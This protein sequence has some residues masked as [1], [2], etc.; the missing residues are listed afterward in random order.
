MT[1]SHGSPLLPLTTRRAPDSDRG[2]KVIHF[3]LVMPQVIANQIILWETG[4]R[5]PVDPREAATLLWS[6]PV[7]QFLNGQIDAWLNV[8]GLKLLVP[9]LNALMVRNPTT[10]PKNQAE[11]QEFVA[12][13]APGTLNSISLMQELKDRRTIEF[14]N[15]LVL[16]FKFAAIGYNRPLRNVAELYRLLYTLLK[17][18]N[19]P[20][21][22]GDLIAHLSAPLVTPRV[23]TTLPGPA[24]PRPPP[25]NP[26]P[27]KP[28]VGTIGTLPEHVIES[29]NNQLT[30]IESQN[31]ANRIRNVLKDVGLNDD[32]SIGKVMTALDITT[33]IPLLGEVADERTLDSFSTSGSKRLQSRLVSIRLFG[34]S[35][36]VDISELHA[37]INRQRRELAMRIQETLPATTRQR[38]QA[39]GVTIEDLT[40]W[41]H[42]IPAILPSPSYLEPI[43][44]SD[45]LLVRETTTGYRRSEIA[46]IENILIGESRNR[47]HTN[48]I[49]TRKEL[50]ESTTRETEETRDLQVTD[51][52]ELSREISKVVSED[53]KAQGNV[54]ITS[55]GPTKVVASASVSFERST[56]EAAKSAEDYSRE[57]IER[58]IKRTMERVTREARSVFEQEITEVNK[59]GFT[60]EGNAQE[61]MSGVY[62]YLER[63]S[64]ARIF[65]YGERELYD[66][67]IPEPASI[68]WQ[69]AATRKEIQ[70]AIEQPDEELFKSLTLA[71]I[72]SKREDIIRA[73]RVIDMPEVP[74]ESVEIATSFSATGSGDGAKYANSKEL[75]I[76][77]GYVVTS[78][79]FVASADVE[80]SSDKPNGG[81]TIAGE[82]Y[83]WEMQLSGN[84][85]SASQDFTF[86]PPLSG[87]M[88]SVAMNTDNFT[89]LVGSVTLKLE[90]TQAAREGWA[91]DAYGRVAERYEQLRREYEQTVIQANAVES[92]SSIILPEG[93]RSYLKNIVRAELQRAAIDVMRNQPV[94]YDLIDDF[95]FSNSDGTLGSHPVI[96]LN[97]LRRNGPE[98]QFLQQAFEWE[99]LAWILYPYFWGRRTEWDRTVVVSHTDPDFTAFLNSGAARI[100]IPVRPGFEDLVKH[101]ME[102]R[103]VYEGDGLPKMGDPGYVPFIKEQM[104]SLGAPGEEI[105][106]PVD[107]PRQ[108]DI[109]QPTSLVLVRP[110]QSQLPKWDPET[111]AEV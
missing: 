11:L 59:H 71:N 22:R 67:L 28:P 66:I 24:G 38:L 72:A 46:Y 92:S 85:G 2:S 16:I 55:R 7:A 93:T 61:H 69:L 48:S 10:W 47:E 90:L 14:L 43:G 60:R 44:R 73:F 78:A 39:A 33:N 18:N 68:I 107:N 98:I 29:M 56:E 84:K 83:L 36:L 31:R 109:V 1:N 13:E 21:S 100:Q 76:P 91:L 62:Q 105:A 35:M 9:A 101:F 106:W 97:S 89:S 23:L 51:R 6:T 96:D 45:L 41:P 50:F 53:L 19:I 3:E 30:R 94:N 52:A 8:P 81:V 15:D 110:A 64:R 103:E 4:G 88:V 32:S 104:T 80:D 37:R 40:I 57:T 99:H 75:Q 42:L 65:W 20:A 49:F 25:S 86:T 74:K 12:N 87:P 82:V 54:E 79:K 102:T 111:G 34:A 17:S 108:W 95:S 58:A 63:V 5:G 70:I 26:P 27:P 77:D